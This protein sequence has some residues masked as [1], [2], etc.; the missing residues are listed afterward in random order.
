[1]RSPRS[2]DSNRATYS[3]FKLLHNQLCARS[4][5]LRRIAAIPDSSGQ[6]SCCSLSEG[7]QASELK[8]G[9]LSDCSC[10]LRAVAARFCNHTL[11]NQ[12]AAIF[13]ISGTIRDSDSVSSCSG[14]AEAGTCG[15]FDH[16]DPRCSL[17]AI[18][19][20]ASGPCCRSSSMTNLN[21]I[22]SSY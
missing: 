16:A 4:T 18:G 10:R 2:L 17:H 7:F 6:L 1:M 13:W 14:D 9:L 22:L 12:R 8:H 19:E 3:P 20:I 5:C 21:C 15:D 11:G